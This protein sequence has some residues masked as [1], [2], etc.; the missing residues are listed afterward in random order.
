MKKIVSF[1][2]RAAFATMLLAASSFAAAE[3]HAPHHVTADEALA[4]LLEGN[5][6]YIQQDH[7]GLINASSAQQREEVAKGQHPYAIILECADSRVGSEIIFNKGLGE[8]FTIRVAGN[9]VAPHELGSI[10][11]ALDHIGTNLVVVLGH[12]KC[13]AVGATVASL[14]PGCIVHSTKD[15]IGSLVDSIAPPVE[16][17]CRANDLAHAVDE[18]TRYV[19]DKILQKSDSL[20]LRGGN[21]KIVEAVYDLDTGLVNVIG[22]V[23]IP[24]DPNA[25]P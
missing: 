10:D 18:N 25:A 4:L 1:A 6:Q 16:K 24:V 17:S 19:A 8:V 15:N 13:G 20:R 23:P 3:V 11:Y 22:E 21:V 2:A 5:A 12:T 7:S 14:T 9:V